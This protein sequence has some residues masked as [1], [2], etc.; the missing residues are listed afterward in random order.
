[1]ESKQERTAL[2]SSRVRDKR[3]FHWKREEE[4]VE[5][6]RKSARRKVERKERRARGC[7]GAKSTFKRCKTTKMRIQVFQGDILSLFS[8]TPKRKSLTGY[9]RSIGI[10]GITARGYARIA[11]YFLFPRW[12]REIGVFVISLVLFLVERFACW[13]EQE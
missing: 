13:R 12:R 3:H 2:S 1:M 6:E 8:H 10:K 7:G 11:W 9:S 4:E 5:A